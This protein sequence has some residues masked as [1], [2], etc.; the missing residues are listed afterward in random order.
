MTEVNVGTA[1]PAMAARDFAESHVAVDATM[2]R[3]FILWN[4][5]ANPMNNNEQPFRYP[6]IQCVELAEVNTTLALQA[7][8]NNRRKMFIFVRP[9]QIHERHLRLARYHSIAGSFWC[10]SDSQNV[11]PDHRLHCGHTD[12]DAEIVLDSL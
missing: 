5:A 6:H 11:V 10:V 9:I 1:A 4:T 12:S 2:W 7:H 3:W 8:Q